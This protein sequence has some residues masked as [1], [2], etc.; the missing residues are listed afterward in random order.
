LTSSLPGVTDQSREAA[1]RDEEAGLRWEIAAAVATITLDRPAALNAQTPRTWSALRR[2]GRSL[3][4]DV[5]VVVVRGEGRA[6]SA[7]MD[8][9]MFTPEGV[10]GTRSA[11]ALARLPGDEADALMSR[12]QEAFGWLRRDDLVTVAAVQ[13][14][15]IGAGF[16]LALACDFRVLADDAQLCMAE[17]TLGLVPDLG[18][19]KPLVTL[20]GPSRALEICLTGRRIGAA[21]ALRIGLATLVVAPGELEGAV[22]DLVAAVLA[23]PQGAV[24]ETKALLAAA[25][26]RS[27]AEQE[28]AER[29][30]QLR[31]L[32]ELTGAREA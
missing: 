29:A 19:T 24:T 16:Q 8:R 10:P 7:G 9:R 23:P 22:E 30:A 3:P 21:E 15:A 5:R 18:G 2:I 12:Y 27:Q 6:F 14:H 26:A 28:A 20:V 4:D 32:R 13:G 25:A 17:T 31:R 11:A 1:G